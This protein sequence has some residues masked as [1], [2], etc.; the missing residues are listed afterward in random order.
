MSDEINLDKKDTV[1][2][3]EA[4]I[5]NPETTDQT[6]LAVLGF[7]GS[8]KG[9]ELV[10]KLIKL[11]EERFNTALEKNSSYAKHELWSKNLLVA[12]IIGVTTW[13]SLTN[14]FNSNVAVLLGTVVGYLFGKKSNT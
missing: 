2:Q 7:L 1:S 13:L 10:N 9:S 12:V 11:F 14:S 4:K 8:D 6:V 3:D 5:E